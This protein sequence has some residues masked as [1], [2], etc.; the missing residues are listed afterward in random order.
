LKVCRWRVNTLFP[1]SVYPVIGPILQRQL[2]IFK[3]AD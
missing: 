1:I 2:H 3:T